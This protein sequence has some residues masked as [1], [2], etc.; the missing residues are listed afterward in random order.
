MIKENPKIFIGYS[1]ITAYLTSITQKTEII[2]FHGPC[3]YLI[4]MDLLIIILPNDE[5][6]DQQ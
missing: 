3:W 6:I 5:S 1:D 2:T 4:N